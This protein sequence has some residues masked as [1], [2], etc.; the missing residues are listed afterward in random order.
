MVRMLVAGA[1][2]FG[3][4][5]LERLVGRPDAKLVGVADPDPAALERVRARY[6]IATLAAD[7]LRLIDETPADAIIIATPAASH[8]EICERAL[9]ANLCVLLEKPVAEAAEA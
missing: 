8:V 5:H 7:P 2:L 4:E 6:G 3:R 9:R 1:G